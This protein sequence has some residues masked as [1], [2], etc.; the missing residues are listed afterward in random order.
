MLQPADA[1]RVVEEQRSNG[2]VVTTMMGSRA[3][4]RV[5]RNPE[6]DLHVGGA[7][8]K[9]SSVALGLAIAQ[10]ELKVIIVDGDGSILMNLGSL[11]TIANKAPAK[12]YHLV[13]EN[14]VYAMTGGQPVPGVGR[15]NIAGIAR[16][17]GYRATYTFSDLKEFATQAAKVLNELGPVLV[18]LK[19]EPEIDNTPIHLRPPPARRTV[20][21]MKDLREALAGGVSQR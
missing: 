7:M 3:W 6:R 19:V 21:I 11:V 10:P 8:G 16:E 9:A 13:L 1:L 2:V 5:S 12:L 15:F 20:D 17:A 18:C 4:R 14:G